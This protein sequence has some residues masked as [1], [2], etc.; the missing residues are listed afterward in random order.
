MSLKRRTW[1]RREPWENMSVVYIFKP[2]KHVVNCVLK[3]CFNK[4][5]HVALK[6]KSWHYTLYGIGCLKTSFSHL[7]PYGYKRRFPLLELHTF[8]YNEHSLGE[9]ILYFSMIIIK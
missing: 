6:D 7:F 1:C 4:G 2:S 5:T 3:A 8:L 9:K